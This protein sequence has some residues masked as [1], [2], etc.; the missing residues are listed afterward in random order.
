[1]ERRDYP[2][3]T[4]PILRELRRALVKLRAMRKRSSPA[5]RKAIDLEIKILKHC[6]DPIEDFWLS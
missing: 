2:V 1:M 6:E 5:E 3:S 4:A